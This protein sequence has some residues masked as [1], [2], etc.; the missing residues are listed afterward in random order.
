MDIII[1]LTDGD[2]RDPNG[3]DKIRQ[4]I[5]D[6]N[7]KLVR[8]YICLTGYSCTSTVDVA[9]HTMLIES[10][11]DIWLSI[12]MRKIAFIMNL[13]TMLMP[14]TVMRCEG[15]NICCCTARLYF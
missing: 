5:A 10:C 2:P 11:L 12:E 1:F 13:E 8:R 4:V 15:L 14:I 3:P 7:S 9:H 6:G